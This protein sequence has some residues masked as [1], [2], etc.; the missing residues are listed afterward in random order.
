MNHTAFRSVAKRHDSLCQHVCS[1]RYRALQSQFIFLSQLLSI[2]MNLIKLFCVN[3]ISTFPFLWRKMLTPVCA[4]SLDWWLHP[5]YCLLLEPISSLAALT[6]LTVDIYNIYPHTHKR[7]CPRLQEHP[8]YRLSSHRRHV[9]VL[10]SVINRRFLSVI[11]ISFAG[12]QNSILCVL[13]LQWPAV[14]TIVEERTGGSQSLL[15]GPVLGYWQNV[16]LSW[17]LGSLGYYFLW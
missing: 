11:G 10:L 5:W 6:S 13:L 3:Q 2:G 1:H 4:S 15:Q 16:W 9:V 7:T 14:W 17:S 12:Y 8:L